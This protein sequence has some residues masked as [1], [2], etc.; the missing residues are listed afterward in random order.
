MGALG[1]QGWEAETSS[2]TRSACCTTPN[3]KVAVGVLSTG[4][5]PEIAVVT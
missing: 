5:G 4:G 1:S 3:A 2:V